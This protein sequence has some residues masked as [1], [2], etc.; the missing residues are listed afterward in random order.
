LIQKLL[1]VV[2]IV[3]VIYMAGS[4]LGWITHIIAFIVLGAGVIYSIY[5][6][7]NQ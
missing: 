7:S 6:Q 4:F 3:A 1:I 2:T 5:S